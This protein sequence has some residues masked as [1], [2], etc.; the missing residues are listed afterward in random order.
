MI[1]ANFKMYHAKVIEMNTS[2][3]IAEPYNVEGFNKPKSDDF[4]YF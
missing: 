1:L 4:T 3:K 2:N